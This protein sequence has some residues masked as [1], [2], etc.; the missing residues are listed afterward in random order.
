MECISCKGEHFE[1]PEKKRQSSCLVIPAHGTPWAD[2]ISGWGQGSNLVL[3]FMVAREEEAEFKYLDFL[4]STQNT[5]LEVTNC[6]G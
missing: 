1:D 5:L 4:W 2:N 6:L 3:R